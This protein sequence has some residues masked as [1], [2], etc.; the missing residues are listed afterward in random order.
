[1]LSDFATGSFGKQY[2]LEITNGPLANL[3]S[4][5]IVIINAEGTV[6][7]TEQVSE[8]AEEPNYDAALKAL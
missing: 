8:I 2:Q 5:A 1:M 7:Y 6:V 4:R 3:H